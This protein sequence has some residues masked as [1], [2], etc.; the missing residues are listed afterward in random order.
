VGLRI[1]SFR[2][3]G[4]VFSTTDGCDVHPVVCSIHIIT[5]VRESIVRT[6]FMGFQSFFSDLSFLTK[7]VFHVGKYIHYEMIP[8][9]LAL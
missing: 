2:F 5:I 4:A 7:G 9:F 8:V 3:P 6:G 1:D